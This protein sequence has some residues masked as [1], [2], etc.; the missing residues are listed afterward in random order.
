MG[1][2]LT[3][4]F[5]V[6]IKG[7]R[8]AHFTRFDLSAVK[9]VRITERANFEFRAEFLNAFNDTNF[10]VGNPANDVNNIGGFGSQ[11]FGQV[12]QA[13]RDLST[14]NDPGGRLIQFVARINF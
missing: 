13:Y 5:L 10:I 6:A 7:R 2:P 3:T 1:P 11:T 8:L 14:T 4:D 9:K 12:T